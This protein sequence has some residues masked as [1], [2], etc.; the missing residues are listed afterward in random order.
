MAVMKP[1]PGGQAFPYSRPS[2]NPGP[3]A[4]RSGGRAGGIRQPYPYTPYPIRQGGQERPYDF[5][6]G[7]DPGQPP[8]PT[9]PQPPTPPDL[10]ARPDYTFHPYYDSPD[11][12]ARQIT[13]P[14]GIEKVP[15][16]AGADYSLGAYGRMLAD[17]RA[18]T[19]G[20]L[21]SAERVGSMQST[22]D[23]IRAMG[24]IHYGTPGTRGTKAGQKAPGAAGTAL[25]LRRVSVQRRGR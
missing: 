5:P 7:S 18:G 21:P 14:G 9:P 23:Q 10:F 20:N 4:M 19:F 11:F 15:Q 6:P 24:G 17:M 8:P 13:V 1:Y 3:G 22:I 16:G 2:Y 12:T 25:R